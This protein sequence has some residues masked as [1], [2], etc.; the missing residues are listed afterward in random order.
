VCT[1]GAPIGRGGCGDL[2]PGGERSP[3]YLDDEEMDAACGGPDG[4][5]QDAALGDFAQ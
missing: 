1:L 5:P 2:Y 3:V 4:D